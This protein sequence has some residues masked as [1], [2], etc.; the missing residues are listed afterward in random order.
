MAKT[1]GIAFGLIM[2]ISGGVWTA[3]GLGWIQSTAM[4]GVDTWA[5]IGPIVA[6]L[7]LALMIV[8]FKGQPK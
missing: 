5:T 3:Q 7:G 4:S 8:S 1:F 2:L 6:G